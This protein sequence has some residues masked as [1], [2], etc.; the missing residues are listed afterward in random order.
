[1]H[2]KMVL[3]PLP[4]QEVF[5]RAHFFLESSMKLGLFSVCRRIWPQSIALTGPAQAEKPWKA[6]HQFPGGKGDAAATKMVSVFRKEIG[7]PPMS[8]S[9]SGTIR[10]SRSYRRKNSGGALTKGPAR[11]H[12]V[13]ARL[14]F[15]RVPQF[16]ADT[17][18]RALRANIRSR[19]AAQF[20]AV[21]D[22]NQ[23]A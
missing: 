11:H 7:P 15:G 6:W 9:C 17:E 18:A 23:E 14:R 3:Q 19:Q 8:A 4:D 5:L 12:L 20:F 10:A 1:L 16:S 2:P 13:P 22:R 21:H